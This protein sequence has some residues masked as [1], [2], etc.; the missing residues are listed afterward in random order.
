MRIK[1]AVFL[2]KDGTLIPDIAF[3]VNTDL[4]SLSE[5]M[6]NGLHVLQQMG[7]IFIIVTNQSGIGKGLF[8]HGQVLSVAAK[9]E[10]LL[11][12]EGIKLWAFYYCPHDPSRIRTALGL[13][14]NCRKPAPGMLKRAAKEHN[15]DL[16]TSWMIGDILHDMEA[17]NLAGCKTI[18]INNGNETKWKMTDLRTPD[19]VVPNINTAASYIQEMDLQMFNYKLNRPN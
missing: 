1:K 9:I 14:C 4:I 5:Q 12:A 8:N 3:N 11:L 18:L 10:K 7:Y 16:T 17:G 6:I 19:M 2:D 15:I 13:S